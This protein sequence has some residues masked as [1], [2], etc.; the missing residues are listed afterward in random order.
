MKLSLTLNLGWLNMAKPQST[1]VERAARL[2]DLVPFIS[3]H[4]GIS[5]TDLA[6]E[7]SLTESELLSDLNTLWMCGLPGYTPLELIDLDFESGYVSIRNAEVLQ[8]VRLLTK[9]EL[10]IILLGL[11]I[12]GNSLAADRKDLQEGI[13]QL[14]SRIKKIV[15][16]IATAMPIVDSSHRATISQALKSRKD[17]IIKYHSTIRDTLT[18]RTITPLEISL[19]H[20]FEVLHAY[21]QS[22]A[23]FRTFRLENMKSVLISTSSVATPEMTEL[24]EIESGFEWDLLIKSRF[25]TSSERFRAVYQARDSVVAERITVSSFSQDWLLRNA[26]S[27]LASV[28][29]LTPVS[30]RAL[31]A[32]KCRQSLELYET[33]GFPK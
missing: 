12:L 9:Q 14:I 31:I 13:S 5:L 8:R 4:Q 1:P 20:G 27:T 24:S 21:C 2:L 29:V 3:T 7:F 11:D 18:E 25:R 32:E 23:G 28:E 33:W 22:A 10:V 6:Q 30:A 17:L 19:D 15:G 26:I 16:N